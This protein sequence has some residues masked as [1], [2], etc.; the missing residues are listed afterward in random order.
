MS[1][2]FVLEDDYEGM[3]V[4]SW[5][6]SKG[7]QVDHARCLEDAVYYLDYTY[8]VSYYDKLLLD[9]NIPGVRIKYSNGELKEH[10]HKKGLNGLDFLMKNREHFESFFDRVAFV[11]GY[12]L[13]LEGEDDRIISRIHLI[14]KADD[15]F[16]HNLNSFIFDKG[17]L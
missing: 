17:G 14:N 3:N 8:S 12:K 6:R 16:L 2:V 7:I 4:V 5:L 1:R 13:D 10:N 9:L 15:N 11:T